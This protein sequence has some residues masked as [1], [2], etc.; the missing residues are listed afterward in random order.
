MR[1]LN[2]LLAVIIFW[3]VE[4][5]HLPASFG[6]RGLNSMNLLVIAAVLLILFVER[7]PVV[8]G[9]SKFETPLKAPLLFFFF[10]LGYALIIG[11]LYDRTYLVPDFTVFKT[12]VFYLSLYFVFYYGV[13]DVKTIYRLIAVILAVAALAGLEAMRE[14]VDYGLAAYSESKRA[15]GPFGTDYKASNLAAVFFCIFLPLFASVGLY[16][17]QKPLYRFAAM[18]GAALLIFAIFFTYSRQAYLIVAIVLLLMA[19]R[20]NIVLGLLISV[21]IWN[22]EAWVPNSA[23]ERVQMTTQTTSSDFG[24]T[25]VEVDH[26]TASRFDLWQGG[27]RMIQDR[28][29]GIGLN[30]WKREI[31]NYSEYENLDAHNFYVLISAEAGILGMISI[32]WLI[33]ALLLFARRNLKQAVT[34][35]AKTLAYGFM[36]A[37]IALVMGNFYGS[38]FL[39]GEVIGNYWVLAALVARYFQLQTLAAL[40]PDATAEQIAAA[41][42]ADKPATRSSTGRRLPGAPENP[43][44]SEPVLA[45]AALASTQGKALRDQH[46]RLIRS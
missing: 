31:S 46:G 6:V 4:Q 15:A 14:A 20:K 23:V 26:S 38:R 10:T 32:T 29:L 9:L 36:G 37:T 45:Q 3:V 18:G 25:Q 39:N 27:A 24:K 30:H 16:L 43:A 35:V 1:A 33:T 2:L 11:L 41:A 44:S 13:Q 42:R 17:R 22:Y 40:S 19:T 28:P 8:A 12:G 34:P 5:I 7:K 21:A